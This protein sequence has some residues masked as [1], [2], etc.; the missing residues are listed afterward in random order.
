MKLKITRKDLSLLAQLARDRAD[1]PPASGEDPE[2]SIQ[3]N[4]LAEGLF[5]VLDH[6]AP[7]EL[8]LESHS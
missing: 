7:L 2:I 5:M 8:D 4:I 6:D 3:C 1:A